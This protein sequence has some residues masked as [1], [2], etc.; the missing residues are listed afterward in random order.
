MAVAR[1]EIFRREPYAANEDFGGSGPYERIDAIAH[2]AVDPTVSGND[3]ITDLSLA[4]RKDG[5]VEF[6][7]RRLCFRQNPTVRTSTFSSGRSAVELLR[8][9]VPVLSM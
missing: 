2:Y 9:R 5:K 1:F 7:Q 8:L 4:E 3:R 6:C